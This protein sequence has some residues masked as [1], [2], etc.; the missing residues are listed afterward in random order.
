M[1]DADGTVMEQDTFL[2]DILGET[3]PPP[4]VPQP[5]APAP[6]APTPE[7]F[8]LGESQAPP[9][10]RRLPVAPLAPQPAQKKIQFELP[11]PPTDPWTYVTYIF[12]VPFLL[13]R[14]LGA[15]VSG[16]WRFNWFV[17]KVSMG[18]AFTLVVL[19]ILREML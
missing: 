16:W 12:R 17:F 10:P 13:I 8:E 1:A 5:L 18:L 11:A 4:P 3:L 14:G 2:A 9:P 7:R 15:L 19:S 6:I